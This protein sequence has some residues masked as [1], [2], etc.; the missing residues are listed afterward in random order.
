MQTAGP[1]KKEQSKSEETSIFTGKKS[2]GRLEAGVPLFLQH[3]CD[4]TIQCQVEEEEEELLQ[5]Q[6]EDN[7]E[8]GPVDAD[9]SVSSKL[10]VGIPDDAYEEE[11]DQVAEAVMRSPDSGLEAGSEDE[12]DSVLQQTPQAG[13]IRRQLTTDE[14]EEEDVLQAKRNGGGNARVGAETSTYVR[15]PGPGSPVP[16]HVRRRVEPV[17]NADFSGVQ[18]HHDSSARDAAE[19]IRAKAFTYQQHIFLGKGH[20][21]DDLGLMAHELAHVLHQEKA[22]AQPL[23]HRKPYPMNNPALTPEEMFQIISRE[24]AW[25]FNPGGA[26]VQDPR[27][28]G[29]GVGPAA[30]GRRAGFSVFAV[31]QV[32]DRQG[33][34][35]ALTYGEHIR[36]GTPHAEQGA[37]RALNRI[38]PPHADLEGGRMTVVL[39]QV[40]CPPGR[41][42]CMGRLSRYASQHK[43]KLDIRLPVRQSMT[44]SRAVS[45]RTAAM[46]AQRTDVPAVSLRQF[47]PPGQQG[48]VTPGSGGG[49]PISAAN[50]AKTPSIRTTILPPKPSAAPMLRQRL[51][52]IA[53]LRKDTQRSVSFS[54]RLSFYGKSVSGLLSVLGMLGTISDA[55]SLA[56]EGT[57]LGDVQRQAN[58]VESHSRSTEKWAEDT[59]ASISLLTAVAVTADAINRQDDDALF[60]IDESAS[61]LA[62]E[63]LDHAEKLGDIAGKLSAKS[64]AMDVMS[65]FYLTLAKI[66]QG[67]GTAPN[68]SAFA[69]HVSLEKLSGTVG[70]AASHYKKA[71]ETLQIMGNW[72]EELAKSANREAWNIIKKR[73]VTWMAEYDRLKAAKQKAGQQVAT[74]RRVNQ[75]HAQLSEID[76]RISSPVCYTPEV[77]EDLRN[78]RE[79]LLAEL[80]ILQGNSSGGSDGS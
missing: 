80:A 33:T 54:K 46:S 22:P 73:M 50:L 3:A 7:L 65:D 56:A 19:S 4:P 70:N 9:T 67:F 42:D 32:T 30:G 17:L 29:R 62:L 37:I 24:R 53:Q 71:Q 13:M 18:V 48:P 12:E 44:S 55:L 74:E 8:S 45:P 34:P 78:Q 72:L 28:V 47:V 38:V 14:D 61:D 16:L 76:A 52:M 41:Q 36:Y 20:R 57:V 26:P 39:D 77:V 63:L 21:P 23:I 75:I 43:M 15:S 11:A 64:Q 31:I 69:M 25:S 5:P 35:V 58:K 68:A 10:K 66:P 59:A 49:P 6:L 1:Q 79:A 51:A 2:F 40:P 27:G 60:S